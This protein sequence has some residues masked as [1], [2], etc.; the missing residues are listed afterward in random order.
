MIME[1]L[2]HPD[3]V[4]VL[5]ALEEKPLR[6]TQIQRNLRLN[7]TQIHRAIQ[8]LS[9]SLLIIPNTI[10]TNGERIMVEYAVGKRGKAFLR[11]FESFGRDVQR[12]KA[13]LGPA[14]FDELQSLSR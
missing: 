9:K 14:E 11:S 1:L 5:Y 4:R 13:A 7:P 6:F 8:F 3:Y 2:G 12:R 10:P